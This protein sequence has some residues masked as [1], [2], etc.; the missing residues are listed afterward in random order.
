METVNWK[1]EGMS[2][3]NC[4]LTIKNYLEKEGLRQVSVNLMGGDVSFELNGN[5]SKGQIQKGIES[6]GYEVKTAETLS[7]GK[8]YKFLSSQLQ[9]FLFCFVFTL[10]LF[11]PMVVGSPWLMNPLVQLAFCLPVYIVGMIY[12]G[13]SAFNSIR[14]GLPNMNVLIAI[15]STAAFVYSLA[16]SVLHLGESYLFYETAAA[17]ITLIFLGN[18]IEEETIRSTQ[19]A[20]QK[21]VKSQPLM[22]NMI[23][24]DD[25]GR[26]TVFPVESGQLR[27]GD[28]LL[29]KSGEQ[30]PADC[31]ILWGNASVAEDIIT[32]E[33]SPVEKKPKDLLIGGSLLRDGTV[34]TQVTA[35]AEESV[36]AKI[37]NLVRQAQG[38]KPPVQQFADRISAIFVPV[39]LALALIAFIV[40]FWIL[41]ALTPS[42]MRGIAVLVIACPCA[43]GL[44]TPAAIAVGLGRAARN[45]ILFRH[46]RSLALFKNIRRVVFDKTGTLTTGQFSISDFGVTG[47]G[48]SPEEFKRIVYSLEKYSNHPIALSIATQWNTKQPI[49]WRQ[50]EEIKGFGMRGETKDGFVFRA[51]SYQMAKSLTSDDRHAVYISSNDQLIGWIDI[52]DEIRPEAKSVVDYFKQKGIQTLL[53]S[54]DRKE[55]CEQLAGRL[56]IDQ[57]YAEQTPQQKLE[58]IAKLDAEAPTAMIG[59]GINDAPAL[60]K[61]SLSVSM[62]DASQI[63]MQTADLVLMNRGIQN[64]PLAF[65]LGKHTYQTIRENLFWAFFY[66]IIAIPVAA[67]GLLSPA[68]AALVMGLS[69]VV[70]AVNSIRLYMKKA[71]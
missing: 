31:K 52:A 48:L 71:L 37:I 50:V 43:M 32:G 53:L 4:V 58:M 40:N 44:A 47:K 10:P 14:N 16:G 66:N 45:G 29:I 36:L 26:E 60:A 34:K 41:H 62:S 67:C 13:K 25:Q 33:S 1:V 59:D 17:I 2:C 38:E 64:L 54:G 11:L 30:V 46:A 9:K 65:G 63:A 70:L 27:S 61:A 22:A 35:A 51:G 3:S 12:F 8:G 15:G 24:F 20:L 21:L 23:A 6:L 39:V 18:Y 55:K 28:L 19:R 68:F 56:G 5:L 7:P 57:T 42:L 69:D 49:S